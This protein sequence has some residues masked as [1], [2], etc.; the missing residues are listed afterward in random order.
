ML[1]RRKTRNAILLP[2]R[3]RQNSVLVKLG[4]MWVD[5]PRIVYISPSEDCV[6][7]SVRDGDCITVKN[8]E[9]Q[10]KAVILSDEYAGIV[11]AALSTQSFGAADE[12]KV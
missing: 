3:K 12:I 10:S 2:R 4:D 5:P 6:R 7:V 8:V 9:S 1:L 11:N